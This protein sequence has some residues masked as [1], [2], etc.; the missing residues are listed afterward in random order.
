MHRRS[1]FG[2]TL[3]ILAFSLWVL[4][5]AVTW[6]GQ[7]KPAKHKVVRHP[8]PQVGR[9]PLTHKVPKRTVA[10]PITKRKMTHAAPSR[11]VKK[12]RTRHITYRRRARRVYARR[13]RL[14]LRPSSDR[15][16][17]IQQ[18]LT[19]AGFYKGDPTGKWDADTIDAM[20]DFQQ[21]HGI[22]PTG[23]IDAP[24]LQQLGLGSGVAGVGAPRPV[25]PTPPTP[26]T[27]AKASEGR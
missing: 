7:S 8:K 12:A 24:S 20:K 5:P 23:K 6:A 2:V 16:E 18:A 14:P 13:P 4:V 26:T 25:L 9:H 19:R 27:I 21:A 1:G 10:H 22:S 3:A 17:Q 11:R 15:I